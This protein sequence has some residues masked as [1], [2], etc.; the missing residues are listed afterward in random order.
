MSQLP[1]YL[2]TGATG[3]VGREVVRA[4][5][6]QGGRV[7]AAARRPSSTQVE[8]SEL[9][10]TK[11]ASFGHALEGVDAMF[12]MRPPQLFRASETLNPFLDAAVA[13]GV[14]ACTFMSVAGAERSKRLPHRKTEDHLVRLP[15]A[16]TILRPGFFAQNF[17]GPYLREIKSGELSLPAG[18][19]PVAFVD[20]VDIGEAAA[21]TLI[22]P[23]IHAGKAYRLTGGEA[24]TFDQATAELSRQ[25]HR[26]V[27]YRPIGT[28][29]Y[30]FKQL[31]EGSTLTHATIL[32][33]I[34][35][36]LRNGSAAELSGDLE[37]ILNR[38]PTRFAEFVARSLP[39]F[40][41]EN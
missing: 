2:V 8:W 10:F 5:V 35:A 17:T 12:L 7:R 13:A 9:D 23:A 39:L 3:T 15:L 22:S 30:W 20:A 1:L 38:P 18:T 24:L 16:S 21:A 29:A 27:R 33:I 36:G 40:R 31:L 32:T 41:K 14:K 34:H 19:S 26:T 25:L 4:L 11:R 28:S 37:F 6:A